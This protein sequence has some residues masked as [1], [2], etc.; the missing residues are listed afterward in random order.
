MA[1]L[2][3]CLISYIVVVFVDGRKGVELTDEFKVHS[4]RE[5]YKPRPRTRHRIIIVA[6]HHSWQ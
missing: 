6:S 3:D 5:T 2:V 1:G 4:E